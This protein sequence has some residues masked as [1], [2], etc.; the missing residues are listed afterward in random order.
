MSSGSRSRPRRQ[1]HRT[2]DVVT[3]DDQDVDVAI[4]LQVLKPVVE[5]VDRRAELVFGQAAGEIPIGRHQ[6]RGAGELPREHQRLVAGAI[7]IAADPVGVAHDH[8]AVDRPRSRVTAAEDRGALA[9]RQQLARDRRHHRRL[10]AAADGEIADAD[11]RPAQP[12]AEI[13]PRGVALAAAARDR[14]IRAC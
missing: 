7:E 11:H 8:D 10:P 6:D 5:H 9:H 3:A 4:E 12:P 14:R 1:R 2:R 13:R